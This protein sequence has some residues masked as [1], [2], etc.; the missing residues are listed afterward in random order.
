VPQVEEAAVSA[1]HAACLGLDQNGRTLRVCLA[2]GTSR[3]LELPTV[4]RIELAS[5]G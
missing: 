5:R 1:G 4:T 3:R 2:G